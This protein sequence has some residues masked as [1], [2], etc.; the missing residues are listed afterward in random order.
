[1][2][3]PA[4]LLAGYARGVF[5]MAESAE[6]DRLYWF[7][8]PMRGI[9]PVG[10][11]HASR[12]LLRDLRRGGWSAHLDGNFDAVVAACADRETTW[13]NSPLA[14]LY[15]RLH[16]AGHAHAI[17]VRHGGCFAGGI[18]G[19]TL[20]GAFFGESM[21]S[22]RT[23]GSKMALIW[24]SGHL[25]RC[26]FALF[27]TQFLTPHLARMGG[28][29]IPRVDYKQRLAAAIAKKADFRACDLPS[30]DQLWQDMTQTS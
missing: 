20:G 29:E 10:G 18:F 26:G 4:Q 15:R 28:S 9:F 25:M 16:D 11:V 12:S 30:S 1:M 14:R 17:E 7:D 27:D 23:N 5:P 3:S 6:D 22:A 13:I 24:I 21:V 8:P 2:I 19:V